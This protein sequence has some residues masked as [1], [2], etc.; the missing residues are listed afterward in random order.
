MLQVGEKIFLIE[1]KIFH[2]IGTRNSYC[3]GCMVLLTIVNPL[4]WTA[5]TARDLQSVYC[6]KFRRVMYTIPGLST[7]VECSSCNCTPGDRRVLFHCQPKLQETTRT[8]HNRAA[9]CWMMVE[10]SINLL[11]SQKG[12]VVLLEA[13]SGPEGSRKLRFPHFMTTAQDGV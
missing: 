7:T 5:L 6:N 3:Y 13:W 11:R 8:I 10:F 2:A 4:V 12:K 1:E 9:R